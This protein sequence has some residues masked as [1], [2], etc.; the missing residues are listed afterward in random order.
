MGSGKKKTS[1]TLDA[2]VVNQI[3]ELAEASD[4][5]FSQYVNLVLKRYLKSRKES[6]EAKEGG[7]NEEECQPDA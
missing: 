3:R 1:I 2:D 6:G 5:T 7:G 4:R